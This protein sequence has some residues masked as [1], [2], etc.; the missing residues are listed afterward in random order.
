MKER[1]NAPPDR[2]YLVGII[3]FILGLGTLLPWNFFMTASLYFQDRLNGTEWSNGTVVEGKKYHFNNWMTL[4]S[5]LPLLLFTLLNSFLY[6]RISEAVRIAGSLVFILLL[7]IL[8]AVLVTVD[9]DLDP[10]FSVTMATIWFINSFGA[11]VQGSLFGLVGLLPQKYSAVFMSGQG[12][13]GT[14]AAIAMILAIASEADRET[15]A[16][17]YFITPCVGTLITLL[18][19]MLLPRLRFAQFY[20]DKSITY[21]AGTTDEL[22]KEISVVEN[23][24]VNGHANGSALSNTAKGGSGPEAEGPP[25]ADRSTQAF[26][27]LEQMEKGGAKASVME[28]FKKIWVMAFCVTLVF[29]VTLSVFPAVTAD[30]K[31]S[32]SSPKWERFFIS[33]CCFLIFNISDWVGRTITTVIQWPSKESRLFPVLVVSRVVF[34]PLLMLCNIQDRSFLPVYF[35]H[36]AVFSAIMTMFSLSSGYFVCLSMS[37][38]PQLVESKDAETAGALMTFFLALGLS[39][40][41]ALSFLLRALV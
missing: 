35:S 39:L 30:V 7:F 26:L 38:A 31:T 17:G 21:E 22:L 18:S 15:A 12:L 5:Q 27:S 36:D 40:G 29:T 11:V 28:V 33:V 24:K 13:A 6:Q 23:G 2:G 10:F 41:A 8:T 14:F 19:Y 37:Y 3:F 20:L 25:S 16:L 1:T 4:L 32:F 34:V 9:M